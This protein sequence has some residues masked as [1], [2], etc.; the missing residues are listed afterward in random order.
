M[1]PETLHIALNV[2]V[3]GMMVIP[4][5]VVAKDLYHQRNEIK[6]T[7][8]LA[9]VAASLPLMCVIPSLFRFMWADAP[10]YDIVAAFTVF[11]DVSTQGPH[12][13]MFHEVGDVLWVWAILLGSCRSDLS[14]FSKLCWHIMAVVEGL[15]TVLFLVRPVT[16]RAFRLRN[17]STGL[18]S[19][20][21]LVV[22]GLTFLYLRCLSTG[23]NPLPSEDNFVMRGSLMLIV[24]PCLVI[25]VSHCHSA[26]RVLPI[27]LFIFVLNRAQH[28][29]AAYEAWG[30]DGEAQPSMW[31]FMTA[32]WEQFVGSDTVETNPVRKTFLLDVLMCNGAIALGVLPLVKNLSYVLLAGF[33]GVVVSPAVLL[34]LLSLCYAAA[35]YGPP[36]E[37]VKTTESRSPSRANSLERDE[38]KPKLA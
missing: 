14:L 29:L 16:R 15:G 38:A 31:H 24:L 3:W 21:D 33:L 28:V 18:S 13:F 27:L 36:E 12:V 25:A 30:H 37:A 4:S 26:V 32:T 19:C 11:F 10:W 23:R 2:M 6:L 34:I 9:A 22:V 7:A 5:S 8:V 1:D 20:A 35:D 17:A